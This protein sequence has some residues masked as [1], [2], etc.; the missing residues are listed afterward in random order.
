M[1]PGEFNPYTQSADKD[2]DL[3][4]IIRPQELEDFTGQT[5]IISNLKV[6]IQAAKLRGES[7]DHV[8]FH[9]PPGLGKTTLAHIIAN[10]LGVG[11]K[12][13]SGPVLDKPGDLAG[14]LTSLETG[15]VL[16]IDEIHRLSPEV[17]EY[18]Y[19]AMEDYV[20]DIM[21]DKG[22]GARSVRI[23]LNPFTLVGATT[24]SGL[25]TAPLRARFGIT[26]ALEYYDTK[27]LI[28]IIRRSAG[29][30]K[31]AIEDQAALEIALRSRGTPRIANALLKRVRD[32]AQVMG[33]GHINIK[34]ARYALDALNIDKRG[35]DQIDNKILHTIITK[36]KGGPVGVGTIATAVGED[37]GTLEEVYEPFL[38]KE[39]FI[40][41]TPRGRVATEMAYKHLGLEKYMA[42]GS[43]FDGPEII[44][45]NLF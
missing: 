17:E 37:T 23:S 44:E 25:L 13:T 1:T 18:L 7:L 35:L 5:K 34:I 29:I 9:G 20:I 6:F 30:L 33:D 4:G 24:R 39:G 28:R 42:G 45:N 12:V 15:D 26:F 22:P 14:L 40:Q 11:M 41:R 16:F 8:L 43:I 21:I 3:D 38:I 32:F 2:K 36:F 31:V 27:E 10:E 19:S